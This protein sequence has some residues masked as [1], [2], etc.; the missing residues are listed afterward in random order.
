M[1]PLKHLAALFALALVAFS[2]NDNTIYSLEDVPLG[3]TDSDS[4]VVDTTSVSIY[5]ADGS[6]IVKGLAAD[7]ASIVRIVVTFDTLLK[8]SQL[9]IIA[10]GEEFG[11]LSEDM[12]L[13]DSDSPSITVALTAEHYSQGG[14]TLYLISEEE[15]PQSLSMVSS[16]E[17]AYLLQ[18]NNL[19][20]TEELAF[21]VEVVRPGAIF[22]H[23]FASG[24]ETFDPMFGYINA[25][26]IYNGSGLYALDYSETS[27]SEY[28][29]NKSVVRDAIDYTK[30]AMLSDGYV[31]EKFA[32][33]GHSM[34]GVLIRLYLQSSYDD[35]PYRD[36]ILKLITIDTPHTGTQ[37]AD[38]GVALSEKYPDSP[39]A[40][41][42]EIGA[43]IDFQ[44]DSDA[45]LVDL[46]GESLNRAVVPTHVLTGS[47][48]D[49]M[50][51]VSMIS[52]GKYFEALL[53]YLVQELLISNI[54][55]EANDLIVPLSSQQCGMEDG[56]RYDY[57]TAYSGEWHCSVHTTEAAADDVMALLDTPSTF[58][59][60]FTT[61]GFNPERIYY[62]DD[63]HAGVQLT[64]I[65]YDTVTSLGLQNLLVVDFDSLGNV[66]YM[67]YSEEGEVLTSGEGSE[68]VEASYLFAVNPSTEEL[69][70]CSLR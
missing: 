59:S 68:D 67:G 9:K 39:L 46:N 5:T 24:P 57:V 48:G 70:Y 66:L 8:P 37:L 17:L 20:G 40:V 7:G 62:N 65:S 6:Q 35:I 12:V 54:Y 2:C 60:S 50:S 16:T 21:G 4:I 31:C 69:Y 33:I 3:G 27:L 29:V 56:F 25:K 19:I 63:S 52:E 58:D 41:V 45:T 14:V 34:G 18:L 13:D 38:F 42:G 47:F 61:V 11:V 22:A 32:M 36:D 43:I 64:E 44:T 49:T 53:I 26:G 30:A 1:K 23:G 55:G 10:K 51:L 28:V 15:Q